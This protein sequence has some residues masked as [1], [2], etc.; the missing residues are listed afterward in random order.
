MYHNYGL[1]HLLSEYLVIHFFDNYQ[2]FS[3][4]QQALIK[5]SF[6]FLKSIFV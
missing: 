3:Q 6:I 1:L 5:F 4:I 2:S